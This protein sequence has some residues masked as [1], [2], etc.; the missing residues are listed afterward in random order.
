MVDRS[1]V[2]AAHRLCAILLDGGDRG[3]A[4][5]GGDLLCVKPEFVQFVN[6]GLDTATG[7][8]DRA[9]DRCRGGATTAQV[10]ATSTLQASAIISMTSAFGRWSLSSAMT[11]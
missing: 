5:T 2:G 7:D 6:S 11:A 10:L 9:D 1:V 4:N 3:V 8:L